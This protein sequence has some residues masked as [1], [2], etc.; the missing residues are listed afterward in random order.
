QIGGDQEGYATEQLD[1]QDGAAAQ[2]H[3]PAPRRLPCHH[4]QE[5]EAEAE[6]AA[7]EGEGDRRAN[8]LGQE[9]DVAGTEEGRDLA[10]D[11]THVRR[12]S[13]SRG[14]PSDPPVP[15]RGSRRK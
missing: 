6:R 7:E 2:R 11:R 3:G 8:G 12:S 13:P 4:D 14:T 10:E 15:A 9:D 5:G 1:E